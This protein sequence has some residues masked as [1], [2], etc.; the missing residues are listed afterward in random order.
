MLQNMTRKP[1]GLM[2]RIGL[3]AA[4]AVPL[5]A[6][7]EE[8]KDPVAEAEAALIA[9]PRP[10]KVYKVHDRAGMVTRRFTGRV[11]PVKTVDL[12]FQ[13]SGKLQELPVLESQMVKKGS[14][15]A[16]LDPADYKR[17]V[18]EAQLKVDQAKR[19]LDRQKT[20]R[21]RSVVSQST[22]D[23]Q[24]NQYDL[25]VESLKTAKQNLEYTEIDAPFDGVITRRLIDN[26]SF[27]S[28]G[29][30]VVRIQDVSE[31]QIDINVP[32]ALFAQISR[33]EVEDIYAEFQ[34]YPGEKFPLEY[35]EH[36]AE[37]DEVTQTYQ[38]TLARPQDPAYQ[39]YPGMSA[40]V[41]ATLNANNMGNAGD[42]LVPTSAVA[43][44]ADKNAFV[45]VL[46]KDDKVHKT[47][48]QVGVVSG[49]YLPVT[50]GLDEDAE[51]IS[52]GVS[53]LTDGQTVRPLR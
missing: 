35:R 33:T 44:D 49:D 53:Y 25:A 20:L 12:A 47:S 19:E 2:V 41:V 31:V 7:Q 14:L 16:E 37:V 43:V 26:Y 11:Q 46:D 45:W 24:K 13:V 30:P 3:L 9:Q 5:A 40:T 52:A 10:A 36:L 48:V 23:D 17:A 28:T 6:C 1:A 15:L 32:E 50:D 29:T 4:L 22:Y 39:I 42:L 38:V 34:A 51:V 18:R 27:V 21:E 8:E